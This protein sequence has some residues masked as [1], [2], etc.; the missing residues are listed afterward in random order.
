MNYGSS[1]YGYGFTVCTDAIGDVDCPKSVPDGK[2]K[3]S[4]HE[5]LRERTKLL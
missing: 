4:T 1:F 5:R 2:C 3:G